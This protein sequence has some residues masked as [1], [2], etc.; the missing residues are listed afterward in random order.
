MKQS[1]QSSSVG[2]DNQSQIIAIPIIVV[3]G[4]FSILITIYFYHKRNKLKSLT[5][6]TQK[7]TNDS[8]RW[9]YAQDIDKGNFEIENPGINLKKKRQS[10]TTSISNN[11]TV[12]N[13]NKSFSRFINEFEQ[14]SS[15]RETADLFAGWDWSYDETHDPNF[16][17]DYFT[18]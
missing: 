12:V 16:R 1:S 11:N 9:I 18:K 15:T 3:T 5:E 2:F 8:V 4:I 6:Q 14:S 7:S 17:K 13:E 10:S